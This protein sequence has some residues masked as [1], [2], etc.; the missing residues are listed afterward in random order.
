[1]T[2]PVQPEPLGVDRTYRHCPVDTFEFTST[3]ELE[4]CDTPCGQESAMQALAFGLA[5]EDDTFNLTL[6]AQAGCDSRSLALSVLR[7]RSAERPQ[8]SDWCY[9]FNF[10]D[11]RTPRAIELRAGDGQR[12]RQALDSFIDDLHTAIPAIF[13]SEE[14]QERQRELKDTLQEQQQQSIQAVHEDALAQDIALLTTPSGFTFAPLEKGDVMEPESFQRLPVE[15]RQRIQA[16]IE[17]FQKRLQQSLQQAPRLRKELQTRIRELDESMVSQTL[18]GLLQDLR[19]QWQHNDAVLTH[20]N[21]INDDLLRHAGLLR[22]QQEHEPP[23]PLLHRYRINLIV[24]HAETTGSPVIIEDLPS[25]QHLVGLCEHVVQQGTLQT[26]FSLIRPGALHKANGGHL[27]L[28]LRQLLSQPLAWASLKRALVSKEIR[29]E[30]LEHQYGLASTVSLQPEPIS[31]QVKV[32]LIGEPL[33]HYLLQQ[34]DPEFSQLFKVDVELESVL[35]RTDEACVRYAHMLGGLAR[36]RGLRA[37]ERSG[38]A[39]MVEEASRMAAD[40][41]K[42][43]THDRDLTDLLVESNHWAGVAGRTL[44]TADDVDQTLGQ[45]RQRTGRLQRQTLEAVQRGILRIDTAGSCVGQI[46]G[47]SVLQLGRLR[48]GRPGRITA[49][50]GPGRGQVI[51]I[52][53]E[54]KLGGPLHSKGVIILARFIAN[55]Y[56]GEQPLSLSASIAFEQSYGGIDGDSASVAETCALLS[57]ISAVPLRQH[58][59]VT[60]SIDQHGAVQAV[61][62]VNEKIEGFFDVCQAIG[63]VDGHGVIIPATTV[64]QLMLRSDVREAIAGGQFHIY[65]ASHIDEVLTLLTGDAAGHALETAPPAFAAGINQRVVERLRLFAKQHRADHEATGSKASS[66]GDSE[67]DA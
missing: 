15:E 21:A 46:N 9:V 22:S 37:L 44:I 47:L 61:G 35:P 33:L 3:A 11:P 5:L 29:I 24:D 30:S 6:L 23:G 39:R 38:V 18:G 66:G 12:L 27:L 1:V 42:L 55:R 54:V 2:E 56:G 52:E 65:A 28:D 14:Y 36:A 32:V 7:T 31:L 57:A 8:A 41:R 25:H 43:S 17:G 13:D 59:A 58:L 64:E 4:A 67:D 60:G 49:T 63:E 10:D 20:I 53:R 16:L 19:E 45:R 40:Q 51:D 50:A 48:F 26:D 34:H 62:A